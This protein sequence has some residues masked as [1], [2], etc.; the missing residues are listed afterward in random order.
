MTQRSTVLV[1]LKERDTYPAY[2]CQPGIPFS[3]TWQQIK[4]PQIVFGIL[5]LC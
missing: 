2:N 4:L 1:E 3:A 5:N